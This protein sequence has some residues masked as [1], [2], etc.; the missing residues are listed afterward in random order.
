MEFVTLTAEH[1]P[2][3]H[4]LIGKLLLVS[5]HDGTP[6]SVMEE[7]LR[8]NLEKEALFGIVV[9]DPEPVAYMV[10]DLIENALGQSIHIIHWYS[11]KPGVGAM[12]VQRM[13]EY[14]VAT[15]ALS[16]VGVISTQSGVKAARRAGATVVGVGM[17]LDLSRVQN[18]D[19]SIREEE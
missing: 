8:T 16:L 2:K 6:I 3:M 1:I 9:L 4:H 13:A 17:S 14:G 18:S 11:D 10:C 12:M 7:W 19:T 5:D 15:C